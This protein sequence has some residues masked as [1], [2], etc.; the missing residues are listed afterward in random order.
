M[1]CSGATLGK[2]TRLGLILNIPTKA[3]IKREEMEGLWPKATVTSWS[4]NRAG[5]YYNAFTVD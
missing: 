3:D 5:L 2:M 1:N 4:G